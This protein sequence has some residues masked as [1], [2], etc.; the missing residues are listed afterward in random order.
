[1]K[2]KERWFSL[3]HYR[4]VSVSGQIVLEKVDIPWPVGLPSGVVALGSGRKVLE[5]DRTELPLRRASMRQA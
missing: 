1:M 5:E 4:A 2:A 3:A